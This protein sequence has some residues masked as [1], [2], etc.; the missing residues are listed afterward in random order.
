MPGKRA[1]L[2]SI[3]VILFIFGLGLGVR[4]YD[5]TDQPI[6]FH[7][8]RQLRGAI[9]ARGMYY[10][11]SPAADP[12]TK[13]LAISFWDSTGKYEPSLL[14]RMVAVVYLLIGREYV[15]IS[16]V[17]TI[18][19][20]MIGG[21]VLF[22]LSLRMSQYSLSGKNIHSQSW[23]IF[24]SAFAAIA[25][26]L[27]LPFGVQA[28]RSFQPD[29]G[30]VMWIILSV[31]ALYRWS[32]TGRW[33]WAI[34][35]GSFGGIAILTKAVAVYIIA[36]A[37]VASVHFT[38]GIKK[39]YRNLQVWCIALLMIAPPLVFYITR[40][41]RASEYVSSWTVSLSHLLLQP[42]LYV[43]WLSFVGDLMGLA[44]LLLALI[45]V[46]ISK[47][48]NRALLVGL[49]VG[50]L[51]YGLS[52]P[53]QMY[54]HNYYHL[55]LIPI[56]A[57]SLIPVAESILANLLEQRMIWR[58]IFSLLVLFALLFMAWS[59]ILPLRAENHRQESVYWQGITHQLPDE[60][61]ILALTQD[62][63][64][65]LMYYGWQK[66]SLW[67]NRGEQKLMTLR[68]NDKEFGEYFKK[69][70]EGI[71]YFLITAFNQFNDQPGLQQYLADNYPVL[72]EGNGYLIYDLRNPHQ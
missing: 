41:G 26:Y 36:G 3:I 59:S 18:M 19:F 33:R 49:W 24:G 38:T 62:Y 7:P 70:S 13:E 50:Y 34:L 64:Y 69:R 52:L 22:K 14:E 40:G 2:L 8:T 4:L 29:P 47:D 72:T 37:A 71:S 65:R 31:Y 28:S 66:I 53:Y 51:L 39:G 23:V 25:Y 21:L 57:I 42:S 11:M 68:G 20:W 6:D 60:G 67:P 17:F 61:K 63:G 5:L 16:R 27:L 45:G 46:I 10:Q 54:T 58:V 55:Q 44:V 56:I 48:R 35:A 1:R 30:M 15:W 43:R 12:E 32:E 9:I